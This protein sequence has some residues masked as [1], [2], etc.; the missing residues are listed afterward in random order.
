MSRDGSRGVGHRPDQRGSG[1]MLII[2]VMALVA[3]AFGVVYV[4][5]GYVVAEHRARTAADQAALAAAHAMRTPYR[6]VPVDDR[7]CEIA[8][9]TAKRN[10]AT[11]TS[12]QVTGDQVDHV[13]V[14]TVR[15]ELRR[16]WP[17]L[18]TGMA[19]T[20]AAGSLP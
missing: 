15:V 14:V 1:T 6:K 8:A 2:T 16:E 20:A 19:A 12:C 10:G 18:P 7:S 3:M 11:M 4:V 5:G 13:V 9:Q 17:G